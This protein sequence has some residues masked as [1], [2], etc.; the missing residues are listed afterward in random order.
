MAEIA[1]EKLDHASLGV[2]G[3]HILAAWQGTPVIAKGARIIIIIMEPAAA[4][5]FAR[6][7][8]TLVV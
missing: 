2:A 1:P 3:F 4:M 7:L 5:A 8:P 6:G